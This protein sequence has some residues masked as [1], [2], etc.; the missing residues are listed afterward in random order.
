M[1]QNGFPAS[2]DQCDAPEWLTIAELREQTMTVFLHTQC[3]TLGRSILARGD[4]TDSD[5]V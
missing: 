2:R 4:G 3:H 1:S 5:N